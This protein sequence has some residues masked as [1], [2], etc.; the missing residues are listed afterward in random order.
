MEVASPAMWP[1]VGGGSVSG[2]WAVPVNPCTNTAATASPWKGPPGLACSRFPCYYAVSS[3]LPPT[4][5][6]W[7][8]T[9]TPPPLVPTSADLEYG[10]LTTRLDTSHSSR[11]WKL[12]DLCSPPSSGSLFP[13]L[14][15]VAAT[16]PDRTTHRVQAR[17]EAQ[18]FKNTAGVKCTA[19]PARFLPSFMLCLF[20]EAIFLCLGYLR[21]H[22]YTHTPR[23]TPLPV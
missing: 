16:G 6:V 8:Y 7:V 19:L 3:T 12:R 10:P 23:S 14:S 2:R 4:S 22:T 11:P 20:A 21:T 18:L 17:L 13:R 5:C 15:S 1:G 9:P